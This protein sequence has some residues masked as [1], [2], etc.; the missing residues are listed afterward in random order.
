M[1]SA[2][3]GSR[4]WLPCASV[5]AGKASR[6]LVGFGHLLGRHRAVPAARVA[7]CP[8]RR[9]LAMPTMYVAVIPDA[10][11]PATVHHAEYEPASRAGTSSVADCPADSSAVWT[12]VPAASRAVRN[13]SVVPHG[14]GDRHTR[15]GVDHARGLSE[16]RST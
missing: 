2:I 12:V 6:A 4:S 15:R 3:S 10:R 14:D 1:P 9:V 8:G 13:R 16:T 5:S 7:G 11:C